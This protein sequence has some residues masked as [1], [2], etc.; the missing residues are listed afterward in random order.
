MV[1]FITDN[2]GIAIAVKALQDK[3]ADLF[4]KFCGTS[5][6]NIVQIIFVHG[7]NPVLIFLK[8]IN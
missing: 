2:G 1:R 7:I 5:V 4:A 3:L 6:K 8:D